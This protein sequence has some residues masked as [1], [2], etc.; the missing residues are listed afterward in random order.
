MVQCHRDGS[1]PCIEEI[2]LISISPVSPPG[3]GL[4]EIVST[5]SVHVK[6]EKN[7]KRVLQGQR[8]CKITDTWTSLQILNLHVSYCTLH[9]SDNSTTEF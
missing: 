4:P 9:D 2:D 7:L 6:Q 8:V 3:L 1:P 5:F